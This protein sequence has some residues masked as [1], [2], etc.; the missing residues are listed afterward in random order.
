MRMLVVQHDLKGVFQR[1][2]AS[3]STKIEKKMA[4]AMAMA[5]SMAMNVIQSKTC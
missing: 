5:M 3:T 1:I 2:A 4:M